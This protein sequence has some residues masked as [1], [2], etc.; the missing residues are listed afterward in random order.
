MELSAK[1]LALAKETVGG[2]LEQLGLTAYLF[3]VEPHAG[4]WQVRIE[5]ALDSAWQSSVLAVDEGLL[6]ASRT[7]A[8]ARRRLLDEW[9]QRLTVAQHTER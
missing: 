3:E 8:T 7:D 9:G 2:L 1:E 4:R 6:R 5:C